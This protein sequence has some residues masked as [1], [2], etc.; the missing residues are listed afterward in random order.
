LTEKRQAMTL[1]FPYNFYSIADPTSPV[2]AWVE[3]HRE[4]F[5]S[6]TKRD[7]FHMILANHTWPAAVTVP[8]DFVRLLTRRARLKTLAGHAP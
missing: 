4:R 6:F 7:L 2:L 5:S 3:V 8:L 1:T